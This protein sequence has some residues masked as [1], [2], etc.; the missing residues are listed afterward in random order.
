MEGVFSAHTVNPFLVRKLAKRSSLPVRAMGACSDVLCHEQV[1]SGVVASPFEV[2]HH[3]PHG[4]GSIL[5]M[6]H[7]VSPSIMKSTW[8]NRV[9][10]ACSTISAVVVSITLYGRSFRLP[11]VLPDS[12]PSVA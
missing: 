4:L 7:W 9:I 10:D 5:R 11:S 3:L 6:L 8:M 2:Y 1:V 12:A